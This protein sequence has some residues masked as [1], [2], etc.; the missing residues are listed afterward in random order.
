MYALTPLGSAQRPS[1]VVSLRN[2][3]GW[4]LKR[5]RERESGRGERR[6]GKEKNDTRGNIGN[7]LVGRVK[8]PDLP[9]QVRGNVSC[10]V[11]IATYNQKGLSNKAICIESTIRRRQAQKES[12]FRG[13]GRNEP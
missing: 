12:A 7:Q 8:L 9:L 5:E 6:E 10:N 13:R 11:D 1:T 2:R 4:I 3:N